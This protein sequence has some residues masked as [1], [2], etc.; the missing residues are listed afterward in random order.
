MISLTASTGMVA[1][2]SSMKS[3]SCESS[4]SPIGVSRLTGSW[5]ILR[6]S[7]TFL[8]R[9]AHLGGDLLGCGFAAHVLQELALHADQLVDGLDH[10]HRDA[11]GGAWSAMGARDRLADPPRRVGRE[12]VPLR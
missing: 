1:S 5:L 9:G 2:S 8:R 3:P 12:L 4:S 7:R 6:I 11:D 10:V